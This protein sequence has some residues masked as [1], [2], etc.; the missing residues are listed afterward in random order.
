MQ[1]ELLNQKA[2]SGY[3]KYVFSLKNVLQVI[4]FLGFYSN[5]LPELSESLLGNTNNQE[6]NF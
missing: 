4:Q 6:I 3:L 2:I 5:V 1:M